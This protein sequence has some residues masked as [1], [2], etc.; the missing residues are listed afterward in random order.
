MVK[1]SRPLGGRTVHWFPKSA[2]ARGSE[3]F[4]WDQN[5]HAEGV[6]GKVIIQ[7]WLYEK[8]SAPPP[9][10]RQLEMKL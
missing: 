8:L 3:V 9:P 5:P 1:L 7:Q 2:V 6:A 4:R 10:K